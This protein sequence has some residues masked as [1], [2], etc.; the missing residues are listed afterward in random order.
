[1]IKWGRKA[2][3]DCEDWVELN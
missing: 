3:V 1:M 2:V